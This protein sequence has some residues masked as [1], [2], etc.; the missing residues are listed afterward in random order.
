MNFIDQ[1]NLTG[2][3]STKYVHR[4]KTQ[5]KK[6]SRFMGRKRRRVKQNIPIRRKEE[7]N[8]AELLAKKT[9]IKQNY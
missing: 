4:V 2:A 7:Q 1:K 8:S 3:H 5:M 9:A 6:W